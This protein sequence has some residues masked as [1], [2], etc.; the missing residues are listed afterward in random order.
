[1]AANVEYGLATVLQ[2]RLQIEFSLTGK[3]DGNAEHDKATGKKANFESNPRTS[4]L[5]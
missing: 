4:L 3:Y 1:M 2:M 5:A